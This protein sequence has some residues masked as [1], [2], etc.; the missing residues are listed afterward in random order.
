MTQFTIRIS[1][2]FYNDAVR[3]AK[4]IE[5]HYENDSSVV[6]ARLDF[7]CQ[8]LDY[9]EAYMKG[10]RSVLDSMGMGNV[11]YMELSTALDEIISFV[12]K[13]I[14]KERR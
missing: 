13:E 9:R 3:I 11:E 8:I 6:T 1:K 14:K 10:V 4:E 7:T 12:A 5:E 2:D